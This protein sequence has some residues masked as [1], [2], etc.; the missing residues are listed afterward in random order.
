MEVRVLDAMRRC[1][2]EIEAKTLTD[3]WW[4]RVRKIRKIVDRYK[5]GPSDPQRFYPL[6]DDICRIPDIRK[7]ILYGT[8]EKFNTCAEKLTSRLPELA[9]QCLEERA[10]ELSATLPFTERPNNVLSLAAVWF[11]RPFDQFVHGSDALKEL[12]VLPCGDLYERPISEAY[13]D[14]VI[15]RRGW[16]NKKSKFRFSDVA[17]A[18]ARRLILD[19]GEDPES[20]TSM[21]MDS[22]A[23]PFVFHEADEFFVCGWREAV[24]P[25]G[26][27]GA[28]CHGLTTHHA[29]PA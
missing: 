9:S 29:V 6:E 2:Q 8:D 11:C 19:C 14:T 15:L 20:I 1:K 21:E 22:K 25:T 12:W 28:R 7:V 5:W 26:F 4:S 27:V 24:S 18:T 16:Y 10:A 23:H 17:S 3:R 13:F